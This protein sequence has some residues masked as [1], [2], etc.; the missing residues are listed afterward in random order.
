MKAS[1]TFRAGSSE[2]RLD[3]GIVEN[4]PVKIELLFR[5]NEQIFWTKSCTFLIS[6]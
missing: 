6:S 1:S 3:N 4:I 5:I 2:L